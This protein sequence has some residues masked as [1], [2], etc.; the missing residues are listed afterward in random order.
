M[1]AHA[2]RRGGRGG[3]N[4]A[5]RVWPA[6]RSWTRRSASRSPRREEAHA[7]SSRDDTFTPGSRLHDSAEKRHRLL[8]HARRLACTRRRRVRRRS[9]HGCTNVQLPLGEAST[10]ISA[11]ISASIQRRF[12]R[13]FARRSCAPN[14]PSRRAT[15][16]SESERE[17][18]TPVRGSLAHDERVAT[19]RDTNLETDA[20]DRDRIAASTRDRRGRAVAPRTHELVTKP[21]GR[22]RASRPCAPG[23][24]A[25]AR[26]SCP[27]RASG[28]A[29]RCVRR[30]P[31]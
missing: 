28:A 5:C 6:P 21:W 22:G 27:A 25:S 29:S 24:A 15:R 16:S 14:T 11:S 18:S 1:P 30:S 3:A 10:P 17:V 31:A 12:A 19:W 9:G 2:R 26:P 4:R 20:N 7:V 23:R 13:R 8:G